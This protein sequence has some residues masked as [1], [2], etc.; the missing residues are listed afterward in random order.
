MAFIS[1]TVYN[2]EYINSIDLSTSNRKI[3]KIFSGILDYSKE[4]NL[5]FE[6]FNKTDYTYIDINPS[7]NQNGGAEYSYNFWLYFDVSGSPSVIV[8]SSNFT[9][10]DGG[11]SDEKTLITG[12]AIKYADYKYII[13]LYKGENK[14]LPLK[15]NSILSYNCNHK[16]F[17][18]DDQIIIKNPLIK[19]RN[20]GKQIIVDYNNINSPESYNS[21]F[22]NLLCTDN[23]FLETRN[24]NKIG[25][26][27]INVDNYKRKFNMLTIVFKEQSETEQLFYKKN[28]SC[29]IYLNK[30]LITDRLA[31]IENIENDQIAKFN[32]RVMKSNFSKLHINPIKNS[33]IS[34]IPN[35]TL[36]DS[37][38]ETPALQVADLTYFNYALTLTEIDRLYDNGF[39]KYPAS[40]KKIIAKNFNKGDY[41]KDTAIQL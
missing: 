19:I 9:G 25:I 13:L 16:T 20:D 26:K 8:P 12:N 15:N 35:H 31:T 30:K 37:I 38:T 36:A 6:T 1:Y 2:K 28:A 22:Q 40:F 33:G 5:E 21:D 24:N 41:T 7:I 23:D 29:K 17:D 27:D 3:T 11:S 14:R 32:S 18:Y 39:N 4:S 34:T 10:L